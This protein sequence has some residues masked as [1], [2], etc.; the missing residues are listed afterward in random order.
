MKK[1]EAVEKAEERNDNNTFENILGAFKN[2]VEA[3]R[4]K[5]ISEKGSKI[6]LEDAD[7]LIS[8]IN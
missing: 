3:Q 6:L 8:H 7:Y 1:L 5:H 4:G 2:E